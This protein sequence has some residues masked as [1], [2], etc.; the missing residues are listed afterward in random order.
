MKRAMVKTNL[1]IKDFTRYFETK[2][3]GKLYFPNGKRMMNYDSTC[4]KGKYPN[5]SI[6]LE[7]LYKLVS[8]WR[9]DHTLVPLDD[10]VAIIAFGSAVRHPGVHKVPHTRRKYLLFGEKVVAIKQVPIQPN[11]ADFLV[12]TGQNLMREEVLKPISVNT[13]GGIWIKRGGIHLVN[14]GVDQLLNGVRDAA[15][16]NDMVSWSAL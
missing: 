2:R 8:G 1:S 11:D 15:R 7:D 6:H 5:F 3:L 16:A 4:A 12:I 10:I 14:R 13:Y 9:V